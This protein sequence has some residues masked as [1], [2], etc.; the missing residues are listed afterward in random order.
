MPT[1][2]SLAWLHSCNHIMVFLGHDTGRDGG[3][4][5]VRLCRSMHE[6]QRWHKFRSPEG[7]PAYVGEWHEERK[8]VPGRLHECTYKNRSKHARMKF[9]TSVLR[10]YSTNARRAGGWAGVSPW[11]AGRRV[12]GRW[13]FRAGGCPVALALANN[14]ARLLER[15]A[16]R[17]S[18]ESGRHRGEGVVSR[19]LWDKY[20]AKTAGLAG[21]AA[22][23]LS[24]SASDSS[25]L[26]CSWLR[27]RV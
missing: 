9:Q 10:P 4:D 18:T 2:T 5:M 25:R 16:R 15:S 7:L 11:K 13:L 24:L 12:V 3:D 6:A 19:R 17:D 1:F 20:R 8:T 22:R 23:K 27:H 26:A 21:S 14:G